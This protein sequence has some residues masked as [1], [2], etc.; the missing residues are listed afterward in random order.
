MGGPI[1]EDDGSS[2]FDLGSASLLDGDDE[3]S[4]GDSALPFS[5]GSIGLTI[6][7]DQG[8]KRRRKK[9]RFSCSHQ[10]Q[11]RRPRG[12]EID[13]CRPAEDCNVAQYEGP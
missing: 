9:L 12:E 7:S 1:Y 11:R 8:A 13:D 4:M 6:R 3:T 10:E 2:L 5:D